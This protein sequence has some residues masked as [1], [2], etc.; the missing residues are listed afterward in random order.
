MT[1]TDAV[2]ANTTFVS[3]S[4]L[5]GSGWTT[6]APA[7]G[8]SGT[9]VFSKASFV[10]AETAAFQIVVRVA[11]ATAGGTV[12]TNTATIAS[13]AADPT[14]GNNAGVATT[15]VD[16]APTITD[17][18]DQTIVEDTAT[19]ALPFTIADVETAAASLTLS[20]SSSDQTLVPD[21]NIVLGGSGGNRTVTV[22]PAANQSGGP[23]LVTVTV[24]DG[25]SSSSDTFT[26]DGHGG[27]RRAD[28]RRD[29]RIRA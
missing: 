16:G 24:S 18:T 2:P 28:D 19:A 12:V 15:T 22:T 5:T 25:A 26:R 9:V 14:P 29:R 27:Q 3:A 20:V 10:Q 6:S 1:V 23:V 21:A 17:I 13:A 4:V 11:A 8:G 7:L